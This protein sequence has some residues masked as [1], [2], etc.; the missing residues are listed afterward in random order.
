[1]TETLQSSLRGLAFVALVSGA[2]LALP[3]AAFGAGWTLDNAA[4]K[5]AFGSI[6]KETV[7][8]V[9]HFTELSGS[10]SESGDVTVEIDVTSVETFIDIRNE[11]M[12]KWVFDAAFPKAVLK[13]KVDAAA[14]ADMPVGGTD[15]LDVSGTLSFNGADVPVDALLFVARLS[16]SRVLVT[17]DEMIMIATED[18]GINPAVDRLMEVAEL[19]GITRVAPVTLR[20]VFRQ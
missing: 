13:A 7:G 19:P 8:E 17:T 11:R 2:A 1:M 16:E 20:L 15:T 10:V 9:H 5:V 14:M 18:L 4:S 12:V 3:S 6:K